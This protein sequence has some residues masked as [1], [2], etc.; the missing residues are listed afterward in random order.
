MPEYIN[1]N[2]YTVHLTGPDGKVVQVKA[3]AKVILP[4]FFDKY[5]ARGF[6]K[7]ISDNEVVQPVIPQPQAK[8]QS[9]IRLNRAVVRKS[10]R[11]TSDTP[12]GQLIQQ[13]SQ[14]EQAAQ[15]RQRRLNIQRARKIS[16]SQ[17]PTP[18]IK[19]RAGKK[20]VVG[21]QINTDPS[22]LLQTNLAQNHIPI[23]NNIGIGIL[24][25]NRLSS[26]KRLVDSITKNTDLRRTTVFISDDGS[27]KSDL[28]D[29][30]N[31]LQSSSNFV[32]IRNP[33]RIGIAGN[34]NRLI[35]C[36]SRFNYGVILN[37][38]VEI[39]KSGW[40]FVYPEAMQKTGFHHFLYRQEGVYGAERGELIRV[41]DVNLRVVYK[42]PH[43]AV[44]A[45]T[46]EMLIKCGY[47]NEAFG[48][49]GMEHVDWSQR[50]W[51]FELQDAGFFDVEGSHKFFKIHNDNS[52]LPDK[53]SYLKEA[54][55][56]FESRTPTRIG[57]TTASI[58]P[59]ITYVIPFRNTDRN[60]SIVTVVNNI[61]AQR[62]PVVH[63][64][65][66][67]QD[68]NTKIQL[69]E[70]EPVYYYLA[71][72]IQNTLFNKSLAFNLGVSKTIT[73]KVIL[74]DADMLTQG[75]YTTEIWKILEEHGGCHLGGTVLYADQ[76][77]T[78]RVNQSGVVDTSVKCERVVGYFEGG[79]LAC[80]VNAYWKIGAFNQDFWGYGCEDCD[81]YA[82][83]ASIP[84]WQ[85]DR[86]FD[87]L[88]L[89]HSR[90]SGWNK[91]HDTN[92]H[93]ESQLQALSI[94]QRI[95]KQHAQLQQIG[96]GEQLQK[97]ME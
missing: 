25:Y 76:P 1:P 26:L 64:I 35:R 14:T 6:I 53:E 24:S 11:P 79:S 50:A 8:V 93:I 68:T 55:K 21:R 85:E 36:L 19:R 44:M 18:Q 80:T 84:D 7:Q 89:W 4:A 49:Y 57:P 23:S 48:L 83:L 51:E 60:P 22:V 63:I 86:N 70:Y 45:F 77:S 52:A 43:G 34:S 91:H 56:L 12:Q 97:A 30:L 9:K 16:R 47:F 96:Y 71:Q 37:D 58:V 40:E 3:H 87:F 28:I 13:N 61:R 39:L 29:Y 95:K 82:R 66:V 92:K 17:R 72:E 75:H 69:E 33:K 59:E 78:D 73:D 46:R 31:S 65:M 20:L 74:H 38:D 41:D 2:S 27:D 5:K 94:D 88:H 81:F 32:V 54:R 67:E 15:R 42:R 90:V 10:N 62:F